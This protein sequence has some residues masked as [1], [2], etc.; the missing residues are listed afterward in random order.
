[1]MQ[2]LGT[3][4]LWFGWY[5]FNPGSTVAMSKDNHL[6]ASRA[7]I[8]TTLAPSAAALTVTVYMMIRQALNKNN[9]I[10]LGSILN[11]ILGG[12]VSITAGCAALRPWQSVLTGI[13]AVPVYL[14]SSK[15][16]VKL[17]IDDAIDA[18]PVHLFCGFWGCL[19]VGIFSDLGGENATGDLFAIQLGGSVAIFAW[20]VVSSGIIFLTLRL[21]GV[22][23]ASDEDQLK[24][25]DA[26]H[27]GDTAQLNKTATV[28][29]VGGDD[30]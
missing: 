11:C 15:M 12:L 2:A 24:G 23:R 5:G 8:N 10:D 7:A 29:T 1:M 18:S 17:K 28:D 16:L 22:L 3:I 25:M 13:V 6:T 21:S 27:H 14:L 20:T 30:V 19:A 4:I 9:S 26:S